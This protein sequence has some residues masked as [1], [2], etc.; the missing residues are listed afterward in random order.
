MWSWKGTKFI[1]TAFHSF[2]GNF[3]FWSPFARYSPL[4][5]SKG[6]SWC[7]FFKFW[8]DVMWSWNER[9]FIVTVSNYFS[10]KN[11]FRVPLPW[12]SFFF[13][14]KLE[15]NDSTPNYG[16]DVFLVP[17]I[18]TNNRITLFSQNNASIFLRTHFGDCCFALDFGEFPR[19]GG[20]SYGSISCESSPGISWNLKGFGN[21]RN[22][23]FAEWIYCM[24]CE[25][26]SGIFC[27]FGQFSQNF[28][29][30]PGTTRRLEQTQGDYLFS[31]FWHSRDRFSTIQ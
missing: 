1:V 9:K 17:K 12:F 24:Y 20:R 30:F 26:I 21:K 4:L 14:Q 3:M 7:F 31:M 28:R 29:L 15:F 10:G 6:A 16:Q 25:F 19:N 2:S 8:T 5:S 13:L 18:N 27:T 23:V 11:N 22:T